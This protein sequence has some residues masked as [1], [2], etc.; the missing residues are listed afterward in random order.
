M[1]VLQQLTLLNWHI[2]EGLLNRMDKKLWNG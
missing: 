2:L 1:F